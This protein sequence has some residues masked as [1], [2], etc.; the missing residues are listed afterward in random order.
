MAKPN[1]HQIIIK[2]LTKMVVPLETQH[3]KQLYLIPT[4]LQLKSITF[5]M[6]LTELFH[7]FLQ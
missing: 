3:R 4:R 6:L 7:L 1:G 5:T 2:N